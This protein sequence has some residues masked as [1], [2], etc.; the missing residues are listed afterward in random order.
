MKSSAFFAIGAVV[1]LGLAV[2]ATGG[3]TEPASCG[4]AIAFA[5]G[6]AGWWINRR[7]VGAKGGQSLLLSMMAHMAR[8][9]ALLVVIVI[10]RPHFGASFGAFV[11]AAMTAY[12]VFLFAE[13]ARLARSSGR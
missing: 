5:N 9:A 6:L 13:V 11:A 8:V 12:F 10:L 4:W 3:A 1:A 2:L 7:T